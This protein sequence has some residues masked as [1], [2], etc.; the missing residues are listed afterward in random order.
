MDEMVVR[1][2]VV[3]SGTLVVA[4][5]AAVL[6][7]R[8]RRPSRTLANARLPSGIYFFSSRDCAECSTA[9]GRLDRFVGAGGY[10]E[11]SWD[12]SPGE[13]DRLNITEVPS[14]M[15]V[16]DDGTAVWHSGVPSGIARADNP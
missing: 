15:V 7:S 2:V 6:R 4:M 1:L 12:A 9:R 5:V 10:V 16:A 3:L 13:F 11:I 14:T 8:E